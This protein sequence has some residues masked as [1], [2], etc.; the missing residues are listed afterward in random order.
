MSAPQR[1]AEEHLNIKQNI[2]RIANAVQCHSLLS[3]NKDC[4]EF[5][6]S[7]V[8]IVISVSNVTSLFKMASQCLSVR[9]VGGWVGMLV[10]FG[11]V[12]SPLHSD[13][14]AQSQVSRVA[15]CISNKRL[16]EMWLRSWTW[17]L[18]FSPSNQLSIRKTIWQISPYLSKK[19]IIDL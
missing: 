16:S 10:F 13:Q 1:N 5:R 3:G 11:K 4:H 8:R 7:I 6:F 15:V 9:E 17:V 19:L 2:A 12:M 18:V 14:M